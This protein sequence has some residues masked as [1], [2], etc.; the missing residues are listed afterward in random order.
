MVDTMA[1]ERGGVLLLTI[2]QVVQTTNLS[3]ATIYRAIAR[4]DLRVVHIGRAV[5][6]PRA[7][8]ADWL[9]RLEVRL[10]E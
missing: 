9:T 5:R 10:D 3:R 4:G 6:V 7:A 1:Q 2:P 8:L